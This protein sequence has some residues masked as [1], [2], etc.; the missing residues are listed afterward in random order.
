MMMGTPGRPGMTMSKPPP[1]KAGSV[2][3]IKIASAI[4]ARMVSGPFARG[5]LTERAGPRVKA[6][7]KLTVSL[8]RKPSRSF[9]CKSSRYGN[10]NPQGASALPLRRHR[11]D[12]G[13]DADRDGDD[14]DRAL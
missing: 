14:A 8:T 11:R 12:N 10:V 1:A 5:N 9:N 3:P 7:D 4:P 13:R 2:V 6:A